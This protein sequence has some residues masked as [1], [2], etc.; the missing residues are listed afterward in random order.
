MSNDQ[1]TIPIFPLNGALLLPNGNLPLNIFEDRY[2]D[3]VNYSLSKNKYI[4]MAQFQN[5]KENILYNTGCIGKIT[6]FVETDD[7]RYL[8]N[9]FGVKKF[10]IIEEI[11]HEKS[12][13]IFNV[14]IDNNYD[15][16][17]F[18]ENNFDRNSLINKIKFFFKKN[19]ISVNMDELQTIENKQLISTLSMICPFEINEKQMLLE[20]KNINEL[21]E[22]LLALLEF[23]NK[24]D[25]SRTIN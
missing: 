19:N 6:N 20:S 15:S 14:K 16:D 8:I 23:N 3:M 12:F 24:S 25:K 10:N 18:N 1:L 5:Q 2:L 22:A 13:R 4:G 21:N 9:L 11:K 7:N 17:N